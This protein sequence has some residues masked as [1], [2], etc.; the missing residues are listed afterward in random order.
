MARKLFFVF[1]LSDIALT[2]CACGSTERWPR[3]CIEPTSF[4]FDCIH[5]PLREGYQFAE[6]V[7][8]IIETETGYDIVIHAAATRET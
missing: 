2:L 8:S 7:Y 3:L 4:R 1:L 6:D 5:I